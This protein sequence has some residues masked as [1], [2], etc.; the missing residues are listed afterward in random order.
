MTCGSCWAFST[1]HVAGWHHCKKNGGQYVNFAE[2]ELVDCDEK[3]NGCTS[4]FTK[5]A[6]KYI[7]VSTIAPG[8]FLGSRAVSHDDFAEKWH[9]CGRRLP[10]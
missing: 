1:L 5:T 10:V 6:G 8:N 7:V 9:S 4:G 3:D 2:Q